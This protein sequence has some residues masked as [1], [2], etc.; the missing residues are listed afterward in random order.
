MDYMDFPIP[1]LSVVKTGGGY[2]RVEIH[3]RDSIQDNQ[4]FAIM[5]IGRGPTKENALEQA[6]KWFKS[7]EDRT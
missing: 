5:D 3:G 6:Q 7:I 2:Y 4:T 1:R